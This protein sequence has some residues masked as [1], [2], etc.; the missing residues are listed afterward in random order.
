[1]SGLEV[2]AVVAVVI[3]LAAQT[4]VLVLAIR[5]IALLTAR[6]DRA[7]AGPIIFGM[8]DDGPPVGKAVPDVVL[9]ELPQLQIGL[10]HVVLLSA[11]CTPCREMAAQLRHQRLPGEE[12]I[13][14]LVPGRERLAESLIAMLS[15][16]FTSVRDPVATEIA[17]ILQITRVPFALTLRDGFVIAKSPVL[18]SVEDLVQFLTKSVSQLNGSASGIQ[19]G[20]Q[21]VYH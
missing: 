11:T 14:A 12:K 16:Q 18:D 1:M 9:E 21:H 19:K 3:W 13:I 15:S 20:S 10:V 6:M 17:T 5:Q 2:G 8:P 7:G 4:L